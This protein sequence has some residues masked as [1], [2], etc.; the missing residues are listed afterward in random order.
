MI[1]VIKA[2]GMANEHHRGQ[3]RA[4]GKTAYF[5]HCLKVAELLES[6][7]I[8]QHNILAAAYLHDTLEDTLITADEIINGCGQKV[9]DIVKEL[10]NEHKSKDQKHTAQI[11]KMHVASDEAKVI[12][13]ADRLCNVIDSLT[14]QTWSETKIMVYANQG[15]ELMD[16]MGTIPDYGKALE[17]RARFVLRQIVGYNEE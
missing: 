3:F 2:I 15:L 16:A 13:I 5:M 10:T 9:Y 8:V 11:K 7:G 6:Y 17:M 1:I 12:K 14:T 4:D